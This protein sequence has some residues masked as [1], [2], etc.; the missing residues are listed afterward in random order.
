MSE[1]A[2]APPR[3]RCYLAAMRALGL[4]LLLAGIGLFVVHF[5]ALDVE[6]LRWVGNWGSEAAW[7]IRGGLVV[8]GLILMAAG[9]PKPPAKKH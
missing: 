5:M 3:T 6:W 9:K 4:L 2:L 7:G 1:R 8:L